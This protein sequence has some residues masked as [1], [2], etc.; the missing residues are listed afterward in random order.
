MAV[1]TVTTDPR[2]AAAAAR[3]RRLTREAGGAVRAADAVEAHLLSATPGK[4][5][6]I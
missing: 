1:R 4:A 3:A 5:R 2:V 6:A